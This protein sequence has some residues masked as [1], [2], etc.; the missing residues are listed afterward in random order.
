MIKQWLSDLSRAFP[1]HAHAHVHCGH[2]CLDRAALPE[3]FSCPKKVALAVPLVVPESWCMT[4]EILGEVIREFIEKVGRVPYDWGQVWPLPELF[5]PLTELGNKVYAVWFGFETMGEA[6][7]VK[8]KFDATDTTV[9]IWTEAEE[10]SL[11]RYLE[12]TEGNAYPF[13]KTSGQSSKAIY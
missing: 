8:S 7:D 3:K 11:R 2:A 12:Q 13:D 6:L 9:D 4:P 1:L 10:Q 5:Q